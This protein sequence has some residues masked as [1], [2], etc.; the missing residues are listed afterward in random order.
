MHKVRRLYIRVR[1]WKKTIQISNYMIVKLKYG[2]HK[3]TTPP[4]ENDQNSN[5]I[6]LD[7]FMIAIFRMINWSCQYDYTHKTN[8]SCEKLQYSRAYKI[9]IAFQIIRDGRQIEGGYGHHLHLCYANWEISRIRKTHG[10]I[11]SSCE[12]NAA[13]LTGGLTCD[14]WNMAKFAHS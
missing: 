11:L 2:F 4:S 9:A 8:N 5:N 14:R 6:D 10:L 1:H 12:D 3:T 7:P 13:D